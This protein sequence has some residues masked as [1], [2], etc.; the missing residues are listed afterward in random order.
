MGGGGRWLSQTA[1]FLLHGLQGIAYW[2]ALDP[3]HKKI[4]QGMLR[5]IAAA[6]GKPIISGPERVG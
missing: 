1:R 3:F 6:T 4:Y 5:A 2:Y